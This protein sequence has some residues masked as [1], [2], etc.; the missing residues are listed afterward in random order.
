[1]GPT[2]LRFETH[3]GATADWQSQISLNAPADL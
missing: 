2:P 3:H 1:M